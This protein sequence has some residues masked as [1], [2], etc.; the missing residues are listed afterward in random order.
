MSETVYHLTCC[1]TA[2]DPRN[3]SCKLVALSMLKFVRNRNQNF[4]NPFPILKQ[5]NKSMK[6][7]V[8]SF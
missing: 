3:V 5:Q 8:A 7:S 2:E 4:R 1:N 6:A